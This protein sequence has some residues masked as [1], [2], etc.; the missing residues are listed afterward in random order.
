MQRSSV[1]K[2]I[3]VGNIGNKP[4]GRYTPSGTSTATFSI[5]TNESWVNNEQEKKDHTEWHNIV[6]WNKL[7][8]FSTEFLQKGQ[9][10]YVEGKLQTRTYKDKDDVQHWKTEVVANI[11]TPLEWKQATRHGNGSIEIDKE[12]EKKSESEKLDKEDEKL[13]F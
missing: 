11:I 10:I 12:A 4:E 8:D 6:V 1:N 9:L 2:V 5:A 13:P 3:L 7:A